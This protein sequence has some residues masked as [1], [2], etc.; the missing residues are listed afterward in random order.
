M[1][2]RSFLSLIFAVLLVFAQQ[3]AVSH[4]YEH[5]ADWQQKSS[6]QKQAPAHAEFCG[7]CVAL[8]DISSA[9]G[10]KSQSLQII[11]GQIVQTTT[12]RQSI[13][14]AHFLPYHSRAP[15]CLV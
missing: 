9:V 11:P 2:R 3:V 10:T 13:V 15:P 5:T 7:K 12:L 14:S 6:D 8:A 1:V 4:P